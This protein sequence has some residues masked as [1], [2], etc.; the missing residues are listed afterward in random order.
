M[1]SLLAV[2]LKILQIIAKKIDIQYV[3][4]MDFIW[5]AYTSKL[6]TEEECNTFLRLVLEKGSKLPVSRI[7]AFVPRPLF[8]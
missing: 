1:M 5:K 2:I 6:M 8:L 3:T 4:T 7:K